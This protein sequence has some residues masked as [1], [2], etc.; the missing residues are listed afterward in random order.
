MIYKIKQWACDGNPDN[1]E[2]REGV[3]AVNKLHASYS[4]E[5]REY[6]ATFMPGIYMHMG[7]NGQH[8]ALR[9]IVKQL[10]HDADEI[11]RLARTLSLEE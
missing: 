9:E 4:P 7:A 1:L 11:E 5:V 3:L 6:I 2:E 8:T 10:R